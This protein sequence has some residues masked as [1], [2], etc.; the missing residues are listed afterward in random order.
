MT[1]LLKSTVAVWVLL[2]AS[3]LP[4]QPN[5]PAAAENPQPILR[6]D[7]QGPV[8]EVTALVFSPDGNTLYGGGWDKVVY[9]W[10]KT[11]QGGWNFVRERRC[12]SPIGPGTSGVINAIAVSSDGK[13]L[14]VAGN[15]VGSHIAGFREGGL[16]WPSSAQSVEQRKQLGTVYVFHLDNAQ[17]PQVTQL[18]GH[19][20]PVLALSFAES[21]DGQ[22]PLLV[23]AGEDYDDQTTKQRG[24]VRVWNLDQPDKPIAERLDLPAPTE[25]G[26]QSNV[27][28]SIAAIRTGN[29][30]KSLLVGIA[31]GDDVFRVWDVAQNQMADP[32][33]GGS[34]ACA[35]VNNQLLL[36]GGWRADANGGAAWRLGLWKPP[37]TKTATP[38]KAQTPYPGNSI[39]FGLAVAAKNQQRALAIYIE[40]NQ[41]AEQQRIGFFLADTDSLNRVSQNVLFGGGGK[42]PAYALSPQADFVAVAGN[43]TPGIQ[44]YRSNQLG[45]QN[46]PV[47]QLLKGVGE[48]LPRVRFYKNGASPGLALNRDLTTPKDGKPDLIFDLD[49][50][51]TLTDFAGWQPAP[52]TDKTNFEIA[53][54]QAGDRQTV[55]IK[56]NDGKTAVI[57]LPED[58]TPSQVRPLPEDRQPPA[59]GGADHHQQQIFRPD[60]QHLQRRDGRPP[61]LAGGAHGADHRHCVFGRR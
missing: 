17:Q 55:N 52:S 9:V 15:A 16:V 13:Y 47:A 38:F 8:S 10:T 60:A 56:F 6:L 33:N 27:P 37:F 59:A 40:P 48:E 36:A 32:P 11:D 57:T 23:S 5:E 51:E 14:A 35:Q 39:P 20:G 61:S 49:K 31:W 24:A 18:I 19:I 53:P 25:M 50:G 34:I 22:P 54:G 26:K 3:L 21:K 43:Q 7:A 41:N 12:G 4:A 28:R 58:Q 30:P 45:Q 1:S 2:T 44:I 29:G 46:P 42:W